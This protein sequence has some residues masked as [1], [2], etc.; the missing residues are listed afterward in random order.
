MPKNELS[1]RAK[2][3]ERKE[4]EEG[5]GRTLERRMDR[6]GAPRAFSLIRNQTSKGPGFRV[7]GIAQW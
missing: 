7:G 4:G 5:K 1:Y 2:W 6:K 3:K